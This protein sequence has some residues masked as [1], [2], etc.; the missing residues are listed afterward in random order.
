MNAPGPPKPCARATINR[1]T[2]PAPV[3]EIPGRVVSPGPGDLI[4][5]RED[6]E[7]ARGDLGNA[8]QARYRGG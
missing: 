3:P 4:R 2:F 1:M 7:E 5:E 6:V 8:G